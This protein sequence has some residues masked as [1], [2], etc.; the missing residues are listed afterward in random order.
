MKDLISLQE[1]YLEMKL[2]DG[3]FIDR[4][5]FTAVVD[6]LLKCGSTSGMLLRI[7]VALYY[8]LKLVHRC[9]WSP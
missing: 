5:A 1:I 3:L 7:A 8:S 6:A 4:T 2:C 9:V